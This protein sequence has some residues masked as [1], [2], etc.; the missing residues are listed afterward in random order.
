VINSTSLLNLIA[1]DDLKSWGERL[2]FFDKI[3]GYNYLSANQ[4]ITELLKEKSYDLVVINDWL[5]ALSG[6]LIK[7]NTNL[8]LVFHV[9]SAEQE[10][11]SPGS[12]T[13]KT[14]ETL[15]AEKA[16]M[17][18]TVSYAMKEYL[19]SLGYNPN[20]ISVVWNG[21][22]PQTYREENANHDLVKAL[23][24]RYSVQSGENVVLFVGR[25]NELKWVINLVESFPDVLR[26]YP[27]TRLIIL[28][29]GEQIEELTSIT[30]RLGIEDKVKIRSELVSEEEKIAH[31][32]IANLCVFPSITEPFG[33]V[34][35]EAMS[36][37]K[38]V[39][40]GSSG[41]SGFR[42]QVIN[43][44][45]DKNGVYV[46]SNNPLDISRG[47]KEILKDENKAAQMGE[48]GR[49]RVERV[50]NIDKVASDTMCL[51]RKVLENNHKTPR[52]L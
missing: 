16:D 39:V 7:Q 24:Q 46:D 48:F 50:F 8:P 5:S 42:E 10:W 11:V 33:I 17:V 12:P 19:L 32:A 14:M 47:I 22:N 25:I 9:H 43:T 4:L 2:N 34:S 36:M 3:F 38:P 20:K 51:Y 6:L 37:K 26:E 23:R 28:G 49:K 41:I 40:V 27:S 52:D 1:S 31:Y 30:K 18:I 45:E 29:K 15:L 21:C 13:V 35:L 44:G